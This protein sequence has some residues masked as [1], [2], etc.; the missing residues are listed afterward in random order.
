MNGFKVKR[1]VKRANVKRDAKVEICSEQ[2]HN[3]VVSCSCSIKLCF[4]WRAFKKA[5]SEVV[6]SSN[7][8]ITPIPAKVV[9][10]QSSFTLLEGL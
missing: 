10:N 7:V 5:D 6:A 8:D 4:Q 9:T 1:E 2:L 3:L